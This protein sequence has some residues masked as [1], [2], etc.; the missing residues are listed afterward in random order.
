MRQVLCVTALGFL[1]SAC[2]I[3]PENISADVEL[4]EAYQTGSTLQFDETLNGEWWLGFEDPVLNQLVDQAQ[5]DNLDVIEAVYLLAATYE[6]T[7]ALR[8]DLLPTIDGFVN[9][10]L[11]TLLTSG[12]DLT[13]TG[14]TGVGGTYNPDITGR[15]K[16]QISASDADFIASQFGIANLRRQL[17]QSIALQ[18]V[19]LRR[20]GARLALLE[21]TLDLQRRTL[22]IVESRY[23]AGLSPKLDVDR[24]SA[25]LARTEAQR[26]VFQANRK[27]AEFAL[28]IL[29]GQLPGELAFGSAKSD[30]I[31]VFDAGPS[32]AL[33]A[34]LV[35]R[36]PDIQAAEARLRA[37]TIRISVE[38]ADLLPSIRIPG[39]LSTG[40]GD[41]SGRADELALSLTAIVD[42]PIFDAG[43]RQSEVDA[44]RARAQAA[45]SAYKA[46]ILSGLVE[47]ESA[48]AQVEALQITLERQ[49]TAV[50]SSEAA[51]QQLDALYREGLASFIDVLDAQRTLISSRESIL[52]TEASLA[53]AII[54]LYAALD[55]GCSDVD[56]AGCETEF[57]SAEL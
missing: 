18:Y 8:S 13:F 12:L 56:L 47:V 44:Q 52:Q 29:T 49:L 32:I 53:I 46:S 34:D 40:F 1:V 57:D 43:R 39:Q 21:S 38:K 36:R 14:S 54:Q 45:A 9:N 16:N 25:D 28:S 55:V 31:P 33:P 51:Y 42:I 26:S 5:A 41:V 15:L 48:L 11:G 3:T 37:A 4:P 22:E 20:A 19:E 10:Q 30:E 27:R 35:R 17:T 2:Q 7:Q 24:T 50:A 6:Q 23:A